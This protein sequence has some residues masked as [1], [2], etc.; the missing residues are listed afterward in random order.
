MKK[1][2]RKRKIKPPTAK[3][4]A[5]VKEYIKSRNITKSAQKVYNVKN[6]KNASRLGTAT[7][8][9]PNV[10]SYIQTALKEAGITDRKLSVTLKKIIDQGANENIDK[11]T[12]SDSLRG[13][14]MAFKLL[15][16]FP[17]ERKQIEKRELRLKLEAR[18]PKELQAMLDNL[19]SEAG[20]YKKLTA[21][22]VST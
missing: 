11:A 15:D 8:K 6:Y 19:I 3:Q 14:E 2:K 4:K 20:K 21:K 18:D 16:R 12:P 1:K 13:I 17:A 5:F 9:S 7:L 10:I 22:E